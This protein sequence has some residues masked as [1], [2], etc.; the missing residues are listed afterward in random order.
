MKLKIRILIL[1]II[2]L[3]I[4]GAAYVASYLLRSAY[5]IRISFILIQEYEFCELLTIDNIGEDLHNVSVRYINS[6][7]VDRNTYF[8]DIPGREN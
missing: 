4:L 6:R 8:G 7:E 3:S 5:G 1:G 2:L